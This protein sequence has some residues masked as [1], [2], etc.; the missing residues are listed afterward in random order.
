MKEAW[1]KGL[2][3]RWFYPHEVEYLRA[4]LENHI[5][6]VE[7]QRELIASP[8]RQRLINEVLVKTLKAQGDLIAALEKRAR[9]DRALVRALKAQ[10]RVRGKML[11]CYSGSIARLDREASILRAIIGDLILIARGAIGFVDG[12][13]YGRVMDTALAAVSLS[14]SE[15]ENGEGGNYASCTR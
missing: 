9:N 12:D 4:S 2:V 15:K 1:I 14:K 6:M 8:E 10:E 3:K 5:Q 11:A 7:A 13:E